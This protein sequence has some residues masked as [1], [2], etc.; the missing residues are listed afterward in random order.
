MRTAYG[1]KRSSVV[2]EQLFRDADR[3]SSGRR[4]KAAAISVTSMQDSLCQS[5]DQIVKPAFALLNAR[6]FLIAAVMV[7]LARTNAVFA[8]ES[9]EKFLTT[10]C[11]RCHGPEKIEG[12]IRIDQLSRDFR[13]G[14]DTHHWA[15]AIDK[16]NSGE[17]PP[18]TE[19]QP[20][21][22]EIAAFVTGLDARLREGRAMRMAIRPPVTH[23]R[24]SRGEYQNTVYDLLGVRYDPTMP[25]EL[26]EDTLW[27]GFERIGSQLTLSPSHM[28]RYYRAAGIVL[29][30]AYPATSGEARKIRK[31]AAELRYNGGK[32]QQE[33]LD[34]FGIRRPLRHLLF[35]G[36]VQNALSTHWFGKT[37]PE[38]SGLY[39]MRLQASGI[40]PL[41]GQ[42]A[43]LSI[44]KETSEETVDGLIE[45]DITAPEDSPQVYEFEVFLEMPT[46]L[47]FCIVATDVVDRRGGAAFRNA[48]SS[49]SYIFT[50]S[51]E[52]LLLNPNAPQM[53]DDKGNG[54]FSTVLLDWIEWEGPLQT[55]EERSRRTGVVPPDN[56][57]ADVITAH[58]QRFAE[59]AWRRPVSPDELANY[60]QSCREELDAGATMAEAFR[61]SLQG[62]LTSRNFIYLVE[63]DP[64]AHG[65]RQDERHRGAA[66]RRAGGTRRDARTVRHPRGQ[67]EPARVAPHRRR[68]G[69][70]SLR[71][72]PRRPPPR[73]AGGRRRGRRPRSRRTG[74]L[75]RHYP[76]T[77]LDSQCHHQKKKF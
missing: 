77:I 52:T 21:Q 49:S 28:D 7:I 10:H 76:Y 53:F 48:L 71:G 13:L 70:V 64:A 42:P 20:T 72:R 5:G 4:R 67:P 73:R 27:H 26:N 59:R 25:G 61:V 1:K 65:R 31:T 33:A 29:D 11:V 58:V 36:R 47:H 62:I 40:R 16:V 69:S 19:P 57:T 35:P 37:G 39:R 66:G 8:D 18:K 45:F 24:L 54:L 30:R 56:A 15:E 22:D 17:M 23:Y 75:R 14:T 68:A 6:R 41:G 34:K 3:R 12:D 43:H 46:Q 60:V 2:P 51:S 9:F 63:G 50:H 74:L 32:E 38:H 55:D 44:G